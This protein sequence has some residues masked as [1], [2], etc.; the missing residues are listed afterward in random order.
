MGM[1]YPG[2]RCKRLLQWLL[3]KGPPTA[4]AKCAAHR[5]GRGQGQGR[6]LATKVGCVCV[7]VRGWVL[8]V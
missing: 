8:G 5:D 7:C 4:R 2:D 6:G 3:Q 1:K